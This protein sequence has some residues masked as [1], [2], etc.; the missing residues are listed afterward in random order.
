MT[1]KHTGFTNTS[2]P[3]IITPSAQT[4]TRKGTIL[5]CTHQGKIWK[6]YLSIFF[7]QCIA[8]VYILYMA[9][10]IVHLCYK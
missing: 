9:I 4:N 2:I 3:E 8:F 1:N 7:Q 10:I 6:K 5:L